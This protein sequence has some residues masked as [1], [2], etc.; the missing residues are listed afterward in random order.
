MKAEFEK[1]T[2]FLTK[3][4]EKAGECLLSY[5]DKPIVTNFKSRLDLV[6]EADLAS[7]RL[8]LEALQAEFPQDGILAE[9]SDHREGT[10]D[11]QWVIDPLD[12]TTNFSHGLPHFAVS[13]AL[14][15]GTSLEAGLVLD[16]VKEECFTAVRNGGAFLNGNPI[17]VSKTAN[18][19]RALSVSGFPYTRRDMLPELLE[20]VGLALNHFQGFRRFGAAALDLAYIACGRFDIFWELHLK[21]WD[22]AA[23]VLIIQEAGG[24]VSGLDGKPLDLFLGH[25]LTANPDLHSRALSI[26]NSKQT[27]I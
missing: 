22:L 17:R 11:Y 10:S 9:E 12:G 13:I 1:R 5:Y 26:L 23:G 21:P 24:V 27:R 18:T 8:I 4:G 7:E 15:K 19:E 2:S 25:V 3:V 20:R 6:T 16:P 14:L